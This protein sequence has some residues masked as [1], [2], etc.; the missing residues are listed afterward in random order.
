[1]RYR[2]KLNQPQIMHNGISERQRYNFQCNAITTILFSGINHN[3]RE[4]INSKLPL[5]QSEKAPK[6]HMRYF[7]IM[8]QR[9]SLN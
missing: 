5:L 1:M 6:I 7:K 2:S 4:K 9:I 3:A 8:N